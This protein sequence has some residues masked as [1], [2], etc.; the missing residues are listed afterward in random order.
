MNEIDV[1]VGSRIRARRYALGISQSELGEAIGVRFQQIQKYETGANRVSASRLWAV[2]EKLGVDI[3]YFF[4]GIRSATA[5]AGL[6]EK[7]GERFNFLSDQEAIQMMELFHQ[8]PRSQ[9]SA[10]MAIVRSMAEAPPQ[11]LRMAT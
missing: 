5:Q 4:E 9:R 11:D 3:E 7:P 8:L 1:L 6:N 10:V 2:A